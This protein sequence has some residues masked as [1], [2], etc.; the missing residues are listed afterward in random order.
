[1][2]SRRCSEL[3]RIPTHLSSLLTSKGATIPVTLEEAELLGES[4]LLSLRY[5]RPDV[6]EHVFPEF[7]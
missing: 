1:M 2:L 4:R 5:R 7:Q 6:E 3:Y